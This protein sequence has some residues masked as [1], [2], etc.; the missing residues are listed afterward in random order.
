MPWL[1]TKVFGVPRWLLLAIAA[2]AI[3]AAVTVANHWFDST[4]ETAKEAGASGQRAD[5]LGE[6]IKRTEK[7]NAV[8]D[9]VRDPGNRAR[10]DECVRSARTPENCKRFLPK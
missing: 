5:D 6:T 9:Q 8:R 4:I 7:G 10:Y 1:A 3:A 2:L